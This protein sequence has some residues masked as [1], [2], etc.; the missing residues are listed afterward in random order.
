MKVL[1]INASLNSGSTG[2]IAN[3]IGDLLIHRSHDSYI[4]YGR[5]A[6]NSNSEAIKIGGRVN[7]LSHLMTS[8]VLDKHGFGSKVATRQFIKHIEDIDFDII[9]LHNIHG[10][11]LNIE[12][13]FRYLNRRGTPVT[14]TLHDCW[15]FT[16]HCSYFDSVDCYKWRKE[17]NNC[18]NI[19]GYPKSWFVDNSKDNFHQKQKIFTS[20]KDITIVTP[21][22]WLAEHVKNSYLKRYPIKIIH[23]GVDL[24]VFKPCSDELKIN[25]RF[26][27]QKEKYLLGV[28][29][30][31]DKRKGL[32]DFLQLRER[33]TKEIDIVLVGLNKK[34]IKDL[35]PG[36]IGI[37]R[38]QNTSELAMLYSAASIFVNPTYVDNF[39]TTNIEALACGTPV[40]TYDTGGSPEAIN[41]NTGSVISKGDIDGLITSVE[42]F[43]SFEKGY[44]KNFCRERAEK[45]FDKDSRFNDYISLYESII[46]NDQ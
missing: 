23:N 45:L 27:I 21:S 36:M 12:I 4:A 7:V 6:R 26:N 24:K 46:Q 38:T 25:E 37:R 29:N 32:S 13:L 16:G 19:K 9:Q 40:I 42:R 3:E 18:P 10:Y 30:I 17:C 11:Y 44:H 33:L 15:P 28:A 34:Q 31:W 22:R 1:Q 43:L 35:P 39:P 20:I 14:W 5:I 2:R 41:E 8:R